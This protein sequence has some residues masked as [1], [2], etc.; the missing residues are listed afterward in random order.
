M[1]V[2]IKTRTPQKKVRKPKSLVMDFSAGDCSVISNRPIQPSLYFIGAIFIFWNFLNL[3][4]LKKGNLLFFILWNPASARRLRCFG[5][6][7]RAGGFPNVFMVEWWVGVS[8][9]FCQRSSIG[10]R[11][12]T[13][14][15]RVVE[16]P[17]EGGAVAHDPKIGVQNLSWHLLNIFKLSVGPKGVVKGG[18]RPPFPP[19]PLRPP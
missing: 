12:H 15:F 16:I 8:Q 18:S 11:A 7:P 4:S 17:E 19:H 2:S 1:F 5:R 10:G 6:R 13:I 9:L 3:L 14:P